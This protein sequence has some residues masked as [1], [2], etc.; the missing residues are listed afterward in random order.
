MITKTNNANIIEN[1]D[2]YPIDIITALFKKLEN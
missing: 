2:K 1:P